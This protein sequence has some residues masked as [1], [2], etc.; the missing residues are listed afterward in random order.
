M[1]FHSEPAPTAPGMRS[2]PSKRS[3]AFSSWRIST[4]SL[5]TGFGTLATSSFLFTVSQ[6]LS[7]AFSFTHSGERK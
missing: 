2:E 1:P 5:S 6:S 7:F 3:T 4:E